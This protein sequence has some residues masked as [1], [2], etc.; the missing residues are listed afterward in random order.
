MKTVIV[1]EKENEMVLI[2]SPDEDS[3][4][5]FNIAGSKYDFHKLYLQL[6]RIYTQ[7]GNE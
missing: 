1:A 2:I 5:S 4:V 6:R 7:E 3:K